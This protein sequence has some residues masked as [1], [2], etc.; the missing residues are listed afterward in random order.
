M[1][2]KTRILL[3]FIFICSTGIYFMVDFVINEIRPRYLETVEES[4]N[5][6]VYIFAALIESEIAR[7]GIIHVDKIDAVFKRVSRKKFSSRIYGLTKSRVD[8]N[9]YV[10]DKRGFVIYDSDQGKRVGQDFSKWNDVYR[11][12]RGKYGARSSRSI[13]QDPA[14][15]HLYIAA[16]IYY[17]NQV[18]GVVTV[19]KPE[20]SVSLF[21]ELAKQKIVFTAV[22]IALVFIVLS[23]LLSY[24][25]NRPLDRLSRYVYSLKQNSRATLPK[26]KSKE[27]RKLGY[28][29]ETMYRELE[30]KKYIEQ[31]VHVLAHE[32]KSPLS[33]IKGA[34]ELLAEPMP[35]TQR[36]KFFTNILT[37]S[38]RIEKIIQNLLE[39]AALENRQELQNIE[40]INLTE[41][42][43]EIKESMSPQLLKAA[44]TLEV[45][46]DHPCTIEGEQ[47]LI[48]HALTNLLQN[49]INAVPAK[50]KITIATK[51]TATKLTLSIRDNGPGIPD[52][53]LDKIFDRFYALPYGTQT[54]KSSGLGL[55]FAREVINLH[56]GQ[57]R[58]RNIQPGVEVSL[59]IP[60]KI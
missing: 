52:Y 28:A 15:T 40:K 53:A 12:L 57:I 21:I 24:I 59:T 54:K 33:S 16:P 9:I 32:L 14:T 34:A 45:A 22:V 11:S 37:E 51:T 10:T 55:A 44:L 18:K 5:D 50:G 47:F 35:E 43:H 1:S 49:A 48:R 30:G 56:H 8:I 58:I 29:F 42:L 4:L 7:N 41:M 20:K 3:G 17:K 13:E 6:T 39:L 31:Y 26:L 2:I 27:I 23:I 25:I 36:Q 46:I 38:Q 60:L 19:Y